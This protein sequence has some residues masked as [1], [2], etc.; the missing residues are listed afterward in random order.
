MHLVRE[1]L[2]PIL[3][4][5]AS[6]FISGSPLATE[7]LPTKTL[8]SLDSKAWGKR[9]EQSTRNT[10]SSTE[11][12]CNGTAP[13]CP[14]RSSSWASC[15]HWYRSERALARTALAHGFPDWK[16]PCLGANPRG[17]VRRVPSQHVLVHCSVGLAVQSAVLRCPRWK[18]TLCFPPRGDTSQ[19]R[20]SCNR[21]SHPARPLGSSWD[22]AASPGTAADSLRPGFAVSL[23]QA[24][25]DSPDPW[26]RILQEA[27]T[28]EGHRTWVGAL[29]VPFLQQN[30]SS[31]MPVPQAVLGCK[32]RK[33]STCVGELRHPLR[34]VGSL[35][36]AERA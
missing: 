26:A 11:T 35:G 3:C 29:L 32:S 27:D 12:F 6:Q 33:E 2:Q 30:D 5:M 22:I 4:C 17:A 18:R 24:L 15:P 10:F 8:T 19:L 28:L 14:E 21:P 34:A 16:P 31:P 13:R 7:P 25:R 20:G 23:R 9:P 36:L 1:H